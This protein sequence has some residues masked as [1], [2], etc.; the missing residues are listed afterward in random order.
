VAPDGRFL[1]VIPSA[2]GPAAPYSVV[3]NWHLGL[4]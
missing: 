4:E 1:M 3:V 2:T